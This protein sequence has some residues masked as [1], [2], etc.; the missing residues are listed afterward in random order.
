MWEKNKR[1]S[2]VC[3]YCRKQCF[4]TY[5]TLLILISINITVISFYIKNYWGDKNMGLYAIN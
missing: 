5:V 3:A 2:K 4:A 1:Y